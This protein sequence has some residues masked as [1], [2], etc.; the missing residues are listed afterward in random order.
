[1]TF[2]AGSKDPTASLETARRHAIEGYEKDLRIVQE[3][4]IKLG[5]Q[6]R[7]VPGMP[8]W[9]DA[10]NQVAMRKYQRALDQLEGLIVARMFEL[11]KM[12]MSQTGTHLRLLLILLTNWPQATSSENTLRKHCKHVHMLFALRWTGTMLLHVHFLSLAPNLT[13]R[14]L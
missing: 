4:E 10:G 8:E 5:I 11:T 2:T 12:N 13:G 1:M 3:L 7:W 14:K 6:V 9:V